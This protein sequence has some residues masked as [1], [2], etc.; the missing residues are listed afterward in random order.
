M[1]DYIS[2]AERRTEK[3]FIRAQ[4]NAAARASG[5][6]MTENQW[7]ELRFTGRVHDL[8]LV[9]VGDVKTRQ[10]ELAPYVTCGAVSV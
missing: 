10:H 2:P 3:A 6:M 8:G 5:R 4:E 9:M 1:R 7:R